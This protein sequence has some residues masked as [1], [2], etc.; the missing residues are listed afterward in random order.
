MVNLWLDGSANRHDLRFIWLYTTRIFPNLAE[1]WAYINNILVMLILISLYP[2]NL[3][4][5]T[6][7]C[8]I[9]NIQWCHLVLTEL[10]QNAWKRRVI[11][12]ASMT[13][14]KT[15]IVFWITDL[16][17]QTQMQSVHFHSNI[18]VE[19]HGKRKRER[20]YVMYVSMICAVMWRGH[21]NK[22]AS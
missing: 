2:E 16:P 20:S 21:F 5:N 19:A 15:Y 22:Q 17:L 10:M 8:D 6:L 1:I 13:P 4:L 9:Y 14:D 3:I 12:K 7:N 18:V 11:S